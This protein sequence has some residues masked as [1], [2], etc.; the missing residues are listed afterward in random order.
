MDKPISKLDDFELMIFRL[1]YMPSAEIIL[2]EEIKHNNP[3]NIFPNL[4]PL[5]N[6]IRDFG[7]QEDSIIR[8]RYF[9]NEYYGTFY[10]TKNPI[11]SKLILETLRKFIQTFIQ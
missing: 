11:N 10:T 1:G 6:I 7:F 3:H 2:K 5:K 4:K 8:T 9:N